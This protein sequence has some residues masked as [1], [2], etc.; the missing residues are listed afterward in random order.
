MEQGEWAGS[1]AKNEESKGRGV[2][3]RS[4]RTRTGQ[5]GYLTV[6]SARFVFLFPAVFLGGWAEREGWRPCGW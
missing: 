3:Y 2:L 5:P 4:G 1:G 6:V